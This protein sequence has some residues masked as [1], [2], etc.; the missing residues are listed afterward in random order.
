EEPLVLEDLMAFESRLIELGSESRSCS[1]PWVPLVGTI[2]ACTA[3]SACHWIPRVRDSQSI[4]LRSL[5]G[6]GAFTLSLAT[7]I[8]T[9]L[10]G[11]RHIVYSKRNRAIEL[12]RDALTLFQLKCERNGELVEISKN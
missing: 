1:F 12:S 7:L 6:R 8:L 3:I 2:F 11:V 5:S 4:V 10:F 9:V